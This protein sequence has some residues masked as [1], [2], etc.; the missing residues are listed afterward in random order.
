VTIEMPAPSGACSVALIGRHCSR[1]QR[2]I[3]GRR[4][5]RATAWGLRR[6]CRRPRGRAPGKEA[7]NNTSAQQRS[8]TAQSLPSPQA[9]SARYCWSARIAPKLGAGN[10]PRCSIPAI[11]MRADWSRYQV[12]GPKALKPDA[13][14]S[15]AAQNRRARASRIAA[16]DCCSTSIPKGAIAVCRG[17]QI[18]DR[19]SRLQLSARSS[20]PVVSKVATTGGAPCCQS[21]ALDPAA[22][23]SAEPQTLRKEPGLDRPTLLPVCGGGRSKLPIGAPRCA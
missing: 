3:P 15:C 17:P 19:P 22:D 2:E 20:K 21:A 10:Q 5:Q 1:Y 13:T 23:I 12:P 9:S 18:T 11:K 16:T 7:A 14:P 6:M 8:H 4:A